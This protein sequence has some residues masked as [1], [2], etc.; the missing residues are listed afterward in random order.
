MERLW[1]GR[2]RATM[3]TGARRTGRRGGPATMSTGTPGRRNRRWTASRL[4]HPVRDLDVSLA[5]YRDL[6]G[7]VPRGGFT[8]HEGYDGA[9]LA[10]PGGGELEL[11]VGPGRPRPGTDEDLLVL[12]LPSLADVRQVATELA[13]AGVTAVPAGNPHMD[14]G[15]RGSGGNGVGG[16]RG[17]RRTGGQPLLGQVGSHRPGPRRVPGG[18]RR[19]ATGP[20]RAHR[21]LHR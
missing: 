8:G 6:L 7:L 3:P 17:H 10:L 9:F 14:R 13:A 16:G 18:R 15:G 12:Y 19:T 11:T 20:C 1:P 5:F 4:A 2:A 21:A